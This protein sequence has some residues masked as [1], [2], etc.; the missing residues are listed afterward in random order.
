MADKE[1]NKK[2]TT[3]ADLSVI[4]GDID[5]YIDTEFKDDIF[6]MDKINLGMSDIQIRYFVLNRKEFTND[7]ALFKQAKFELYSR[8]QALIELYYEWKTAVAKNKQYS[9]EYNKLKPRKP[10][11]L[12]FLSLNKDSDEIKE[13]K[14]ELIQIKIERNK[15]KMLNIKKQIQDK[16]KETNSFYKIYKDYKYIEELSEE[17]LKKLE[18]ESWKLK[19]CYYP[20]LV[21]RYNFTPKGYVPYAHETDPKFLETNT[22]L[23]DELLLENSLLNNKRHLKEIGSD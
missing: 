23:L 4:V 9:G 8:I 6:D 1:S 3:F 22:K 17:E 5:R 12:L 19:S 21:T 7:F 18:E 10:R 14:S 13:G 2:E 20:E 15:I 11:R 16:L